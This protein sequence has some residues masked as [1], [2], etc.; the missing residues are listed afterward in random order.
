M[1]KNTLIPFSSNLGLLTN[2]REFRTFIWQNSHMWGNEGERHTSIK[3]QL[4]RITFLKIWIFL[5]LWFKRKS[6]LLVYEITIFV[7]AIVS[8]YGAIHSL[9]KF[10]D[11]CVFFF[12]VVHC[13]LTLTPCLPSFMSCTRFYLLTLIS[14]CC[15]ECVKTY[16][17]Y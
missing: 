9:L 7:T 4:F 8:H 10:L 5:L 13:L 11:T 2:D 12:F 6:K 14:C 17:V 1:S 3:S 16:T 15:E